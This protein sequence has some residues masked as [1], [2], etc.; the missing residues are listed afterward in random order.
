MES[1]PVN[2]E[3]LDA[4][5]IDFAK[6]E[7]LIEDSSAPSSSPSPSPS[8]SS[9][10][11]HSRLVIRQIRRAVETGAIDAAVALLRL[12]APSILTDHKILF[13]LH[14][15]K[16]IELLRKGT[17]EDRDSAIECLRTALAPCALDAYPEAYE[18]FKHVLLAFIY[19]KDDKNSP[20]ANEVVARKQRAVWLEYSV[21]RARAAAS[22]PGCSEKRIR[23]GTWNI[24]TL[25]GKSMEI[26]DVMVRRKINFMCLQETKWT[27]EKAK[28]LDNSGFKLWYTGKIRSRNGIGIIVDKEW[29]KDVV[30]VRRVGDRI[31]VLKLVVGQ[32]TFNVISGYAPQVG[33]AEHFKVKFWEDLEG[34]LQDIPQG[35]KVFLGG[36]LNGH[37]GS[38]ARGFEGVHGG[39]GLGEMNGE[40]KSI[41]EFSEAL[42]LSIANT[43]FKK[44]EEH[45]ITYKSGGTCSQ[46]DF[47]LIRKSDRK[48]CLNCKVIPGESL[49][50]QH[51][52][53]VMDVRIRDR[54]K[55]RSPLVAPRIKWWHL[56]GEKQGIFQQKIWEGWC[57]Q[58]QGS[59]NDMWNKMSQEIIKVAKETLGES[60]GFG[61]RGKES[62]WWNENVQ[63]KVRVK[64]ECFKEWSR[65]RNSETWDKYKIAR[66]E[67]KK[68][69]SEARAQAFDG[70]YQALG[71]RDGE[72]SIYRLAKG[73]E[74]KTR[75]LD[76][77]KCVKDEEGKVLV[78]EKDIKE[79]WKAYFHNLF[80]DGYGYDSSSLD[81]REEDR[82]YKYYR[83]IQKQ[84]V[85]EALKRMSNGKAV[86]PDNIPIEVWKTLGD[87]GLEWLTEL[88]NEIMRSKRMPEEWRRSTGV[89]LM[90]HTMK[91]WERVIERR[92]RKETQVTEN[93]FGF[94]PGRSTMEAIYLL[95]RVME[96]YRMAQQDLH[97]IFIDLEKAYD[98]VPREI[99]WKVL[100]KKGVRVAYIRAIQDMYDRVSTSVRTQ[101]GESDD[102]PITIG[103]HQGSTLSPYLF[104]LI[105]DVL[106]EQIQEIAPRCMFFADDIVL[107]G[108]SREELNERLETWRR[109]LETHGFRLSRSKSEY[110]EC[111]F[112]KRRRVSNSE[113]KIG[114]HIIPQVTRFK[115]LGSVIQD[116]GEIEGD[117]NH[118]IQAGWMKWR[119][120]SGVLCDAKV[121][122]KLK[123]KFYRT[124][125]RPAILYGT[126]CWAVKSQHENKVGVAE[127]RMLRW[128]CGKTR[129]DKIRNE[130][131][132]E[133]VGVV[134]IVEKMVENRL[135]WFGHVERRPV[136]SVVRRVDQM[137]RRQIIRGR[138]RPKKT[139]REVIK[140][141]LE[142][143]GLDRSMWSEHRRLD[144][145]GFMSSMLRAHLNAY[146]P[147][148]S[149][150][151][152]YLISIHRVYCLRQGITSPISDLTE[153]LLLEERD[154]PATPQD[155]LYEVP[156]FDEVD[157][158]ALAHAVELTRQGAIDSLRF[159][160]GD[161][162]LAFQ[163]ELCRMRLDAPL[164]D[165]LVREYCVY[166]GIVDS[167]SG[168]QPIPETVKFNPQDPGYCSSRDCSLELDCNASKHSD[169]ETSVTNAQMDGS[170]EN[171]T[172]VTSMRRIDFEVRYASEL[173][174][175]HEDCSTSGSQQHE[176]ASVLQR[177][178]LPGNGERSKRKR[179][180]GRY[181]DNSYMPNASLEENSKQEHSISTI[182]ST[183]S[184]E[185]QGSEKLSVHDISNVE[186]RYEILLGMKELASKGMAAEA[187]EE[188]NA[189]DPNFFAQNSVEFL[190]L[191]SSGDYNT[192]L[193][194]ACTHLGPLAACDPA[195]LKPLKETLLALLR[196]NEDALGNALPLHALAASLQVAVGRRLGVEEPQLMKIMRATLYTHNEWFK[197]QMCKDRFE[198]LL[199][200]DSLKEANTPF[201]APVSTSKSYA[202]SC[203][204]G[205][206]QA[207]VSSGTRMSEDGSSPTQASSRD[208][209][210]DEGAI[211]KVMEFLALPRADAIHLLAQYN[212]NAETVIQQIFP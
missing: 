22:L 24:G 4:L 141:N 86:G 23:F 157:I 49:T 32:D 134:P 107:L 81:T 106:T 36:D 121:P 78:H 85:K 51:R 188:V 102:F 45:L 186:D 96:Q 72:R 177:S 82:N 21:K 57:G 61:P 193:K 162:F 135:R 39:F 13:R 108:E 117:V 83:R 17:A 19:D 67:T 94:M 110:M 199:R 63:S 145:A 58:S 29:K 210:C 211:L 3:A 132:R 59:A 129:Q 105:L 37:V 207:T 80:N 55:R 175:I 198:G 28:E 206:S 109:A 212:G 20:V 111:K 154:P 100:E 6:S 196:P 76:Q 122:I 184:K 173:A 138:G 164:L 79:R 71:T 15:Q 120:A 156:P 26:V 65:C 60:R 18:E 202:D 127:M 16:F 167:A 146:D 181:D 179:W 160:K 191:V 197:L 74:R 38:V 64:K 165:Q 158:Q 1:T 139:I 144:L 153:R 77:V 136:D 50:T 203:T 130:A 200:L 95:R 91:L 169:G 205:S 101:G 163:N 195:L 190:K 31:I 155:I 201:L 11:Y 143:N 53:L 123:G 7:N 131:I 180:R 176:D 119:K 10:S 103:L 112:N 152:R 73:R 75:D 99:L 128:M 113:V 27:G 30:D 87:R 126:E 54:A 159:T 33:L 149:M 185:K 204:N 147:I 118:R 168:K 194:V 182:V 170:P 5:L 97:L 171:N 70:L 41:L 9:S 114:D 174:S 47:F 187:V 93:Q 34:V 12:H 2:W 183:I 209:I 62:W 35:E 92:L 56:K 68:A 189:I 104:T 40:G 8:P 42:D 69:V 44:R 89:K 192:A 208:V 150:A 66:N 98:R 140:K 137:E 25:T 90:S 151:L 116:D 125:V 14:K 166:R 43:W 133:R 178:R 48:Y 161:V 84:E 172:D 88:F 115:Y 46:I 52:V 148:F 124:A 142:I